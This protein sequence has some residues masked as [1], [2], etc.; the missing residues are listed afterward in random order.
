MVKD[1]LDGHWRTDGKF[2]RVGDRRVWIKAVTYG[3]FPG[4]WPDSFDSDFSQIGAAGFNSLRLYELPEKS[5]L[6]AAANHGFKVFGGLNWRMNADFL[7]CPA[8]FS[9]AAV[10]LQ[11]YL[12]ETAQ[13]PA[14]AG[15]FVGN[16][17]LADLV[18]WMGPVEVREKIEELITIGKSLAP[19][20]LFAYANY[21]STEYLEPENADFSAFNIYLEDPKAFRNYMQR[22]HHI[23][24]DR[25]LVISE[26]GLDSQRNGLEKQAEA[27][28]WAWQI[29]AEQEVAGMTAYSWSD[30]WLNNGEEVLDWDFGITDRAG[31]PKPALQAIREALPNFPAALQSDLSISVIVCT[32]NGKGRIEACL[33]A[34]Q[35]IRGGH[36]ETIVVDDGSTDGTG[37]VVA[38]QF[39]WVRLLRLQPGGLSAARNAGAAAAVGKILAFTDDDC[40]PDKEWLPRLREIFETGMYA[41]VG[42]PNLPPAPKSWQAAV[43]CASPGAPS[44]VMLSDVEAEH[45]P[46]CNLAVTKEAF[47]AI[48]GFDPIF[49]TAGDDVDF[50]WRLRSAGYRLGFAAGAFVWHWRRPSL[51][52][53][54]R[55]QLG[56]GRA[57]KLL[58]GKHPEKF[59]KHG[60]AKWDGFIYGG[61]PV[62]AVR[63]SVIY[64]GAMGN[65]GYQSVL[66]RMLPL[67][68]IAAD[69]DH[70]KSRAALAL[71]H[72]LQPRLRAWERNRRWCFSAKRVHGISPPSPVATFA[73]SSRNG[74]DRHDFIRSLLSDGW[75]AGGN[76]DSWDVEKNGT[77]LLLATERGEN[78]ETRTLVRV[79]GDD[80]PEL[81]QWFHSQ[82]A[83]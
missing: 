73:I 14:L 74:M 61:G 7:D 37:D 79:W 72:F 16:E 3:P 8:L 75:S 83:K 57:E 76:L 18:R 20:V 50:C 60:Q 6:D 38:E 29:A 45:L 9:A 27:F 26:F 15:I 80:S 21:P 28:R 81:R 32:R 54:L 71:I 44:H 68:G 22:L 12:R 35:Q 10:Q 40:E 77:R 43:V 62:R 53:F 2:F 25:P 39:P 58:I 13:H 48:G 1:S 30:R 78:Q 55:Q 33:E 46:G 36:F 70:F 66:N 34:I 11:E 42:G 52:A 67:R 64:H 5:L 63:D 59:S 41:A 19:N 17:I 24:G 47:D 51:V 23:A 65:A 69:F 49:R 31:K 56:Y 4:G 82:A